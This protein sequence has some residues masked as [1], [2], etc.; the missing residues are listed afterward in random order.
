MV[1]G[2]INMV[3]VAIA[4]GCAGIIVGSVSSTGLSNAMVEVVEIVSGGNYLHL[5]FHGDDTL[6]SLRF[7]VAYHCQLPSSSRVT[8]E[9]CC[10][11]W[12]ERLDIYCR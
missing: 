8:G 10:G 1:R 2:A 7:R 9:C 5:T 3:P 11:N 12:R 4:I 6:L